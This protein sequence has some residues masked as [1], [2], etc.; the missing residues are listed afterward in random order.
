MRSSPS[1]S[2]EIAG[3]GIR[4]TL[5]VALVT[6]AQNETWRSSDG[7]TQGHLSAHHGVR[8]QLQDSSLGDDDH[9]AFLGMV[10]DL[11]REVALARDDPHRWDIL[12]NTNT[13][14]A[15]DLMERISSFRVTSAPMPVASGAEPAPIRDVRHDAVAQRVE[16][17]LGLEP[18][19]SGIPQTMTL[20]LPNDTIVARTEMVDDLTFKAHFDTDFNGVMGTVDVVGTAEPGSLVTL[21]VTTSRRVV[22]GAGRRCRCGRWR[23]W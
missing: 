21:D 11:E 1:M 5:C 7:R 18:G 17:D 6:G 14:V 3:H 16:V 12:L 4:A 9:A 15:V 8:N 23:R 19:Q 2:D 13:S 20:R 10:D 22:G